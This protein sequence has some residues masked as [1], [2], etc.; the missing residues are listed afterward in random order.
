MFN[1]LPKVT[2]EVAYRL[3]EKDVA[4]FSDLYKNDPKKAKEQVESALQEISKE[5]NPYL[6]KAIDAGV[7]G[8]LSLVEDQF[9]SK[10]LED[11]R[12][13]SLKGYLLVCEALEAAAW[14]KEMGKEL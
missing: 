5:G 1:H 8:T 6:A 12:I 11:L 2:K 14:A 10:D 9:E 3:M 13:F 4:E 7:N